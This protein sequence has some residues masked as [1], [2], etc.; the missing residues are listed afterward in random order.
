MCDVKLQLKQEVSF[1]PERDRSQSDIE[2]LR[3][4]GIIFYHILPRRR[5]GDYCNIY[6][7]LSTT[8]ESLAINNFFH[9][10]GMVS[11]LNV[12]FISYLCLS[13]WNEEESIP[14]EEF[15]LFLVG[16]QNSCKVC[17]LDKTERC[18]WYW[19]FCLGGGEWRMEEYLNRIEDTPVWSL[20]PLLV[21][22]E[23][24]YMRPLL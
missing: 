22:K 11:H 4:R 3:I 5:R 18:S 10:F 12:I 16:L 7:V 9:T 8:I 21:W 6:R 19:S 23:V 14:S 13:S 15:V 17:P 2:N 1:P 24:V 20:P